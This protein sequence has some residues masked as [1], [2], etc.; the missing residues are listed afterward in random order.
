MGSLYS[1][2]NGFDW[3]L[4][5]DKV[6]KIK[7]WVTLTNRQKRSLTV[8][9]NSE[10]LSIQM[11]HDQTSLEVQCSSGEWG[12]VSGKWEEEERKREKHGTESRN[13]DKRWEY[14]Q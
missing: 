12:R 11:L 7:W 10:S 14:E 8:K 5:K 3:S 6:G 13:S 2:Q 9:E 4:G 1:C